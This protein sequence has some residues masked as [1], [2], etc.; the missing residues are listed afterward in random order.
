MAG[1]DFKWRWAN[2]DQSGRA[3]YYVDIINQSRPDDELSHFPQAMAALRAGK[4]V[5]CQK[6]L[7]LTIAE[8]KLLCKTV[9]ET[10]RVF[11]RWQHVRSWTAESLSRRLRDN[12]FEVVRVI[13]T[14]LAMRR[15]RT[16]MGY[17]K[18]LLKRVMLGDQGK[19]HLIC[20]ARLGRPESGRVEI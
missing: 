9:K 14:N 4:D 3:D 19:P 10:G 18:T 12:H 16:P 15:T 8:G 7:T 11:H 2:V 20:V 17:F 5:H 1:K 13:E 6:P